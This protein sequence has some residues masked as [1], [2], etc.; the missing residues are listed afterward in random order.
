MANYQVVWRGP[1]YDA[2]G[3]GTASRE[4]VFQLDRQGVDVKIEAYRWGIPLIEIDKLEKDRLKKL[5]EKPYAKNKR[6]VLIYH[7]PPWKIDTKK[8][9][10]QFDYLILNTVWE[11]ARMPNSWLLTIN[12]F[13]AACVPSTHNMEAM[14][15][16]GVHVPL[17]LVPH[18]VDTNKYKPENRKLSIK[19][20]EGKFI[21][22]SVF[23]FNHR[24][25]PETLLRAYWEEFKA[26]DHVALVIKT[27]KKYW[28]GSSKQR[29]RNRITEY[30]K[31]L[32]FGDET[33]PVYLFTD[34]F[35]EMILTGI[36]TLGHVFVLPTRG[37]GVGLPFMEAL[38][39]GI[40]VIATGWGGQMDFLNERNSFLI[41]YQLKYPGI[42]MNSEHAISS[43]YRDLFEE[44]GQLWAEPDLRDLKR[45]MRYAYEN[46]NLC[47]KKG[48]QGRKDML[49]FSW[50][51]AGIALQQTVEKVIDN[52]KS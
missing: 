33:A 42:S 25:N 27:A 6:K 44:E 52:K 23:D 1:V 7:S 26:D 29:V 39:S 46:P 47:K 34:V 38:S 5:I 30:K 12:Q 8:E 32:G 14:G 35:E 11:A 3:Y 49:P 4:Y 9:R 16:S 28:D 37:E 41:E 50:N 48:K 45:K 43:V 18:G 40:P 36:Y 2:T 21:F 20:A 31:R 51:K 22:I 15:N 10:K 17:F 24:K 13:D 19:E